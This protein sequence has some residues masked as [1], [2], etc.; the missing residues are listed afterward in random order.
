MSAMMRMTC[1]FH[2]ANLGCVNADISTVL[3]SM[4]SNQLMLGGIG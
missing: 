4:Q 2:V 3:G 1:K